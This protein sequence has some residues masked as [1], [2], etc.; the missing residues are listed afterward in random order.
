VQVL[1]EADALLRLHV[2]RSPDAP[3]IAEA[4]IVEL[5]KR[6]VMLAILNIDCEHN[7]LTPD[8]NVRERLVAALN[9]ADDYSRLLLQ[10]RVSG[11]QDQKDVSRVDG[12]SCKRGTGSTASNNEVIR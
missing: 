8:G 11:W 2:V 1:R 9:R 7:G 5:L 6:A 4:E 3:V 10:G 12:E